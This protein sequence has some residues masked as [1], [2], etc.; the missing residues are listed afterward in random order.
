[1]SS[2]HESVNLMLVQP[3]LRKQYLDPEIAQIANDKEKEHGEIRGKA[4]A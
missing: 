3:Q 2:S 4:I 1:M